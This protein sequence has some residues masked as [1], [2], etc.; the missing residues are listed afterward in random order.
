MLDSSILYSQEV[1]RTPPRRAQ[2]VAFIEEPFALSK[3]T[4]GLLLTL[5]MVVCALICCTIARA[6]GRRSS[7]DYKTTYAA[8][9]ECSALHSV[10]HLTQDAAFYV[11]DCWRAGPPMRCLGPVKMETTKMKGRTMRW[12]GCRTVECNRATVRRPYFCLPCCADHR[13]CL[14]ELCDADMIARVQRVPAAHVWQSR[15]SV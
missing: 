10:E 15:S 9:T 1:V 12:T 5:G 2:Q 3:N 6:V 14:N 7:S 13:A 11:S 4:T 8:R